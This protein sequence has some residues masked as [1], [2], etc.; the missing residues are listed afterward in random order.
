MNIIE[1]LY[2][3]YAELC[4]QIPLPTEKLSELSRKIELYERI[5]GKITNDN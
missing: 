1:Q 4:K 5:A 3:E 2:A